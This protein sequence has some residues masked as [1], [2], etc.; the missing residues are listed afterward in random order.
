MIE[1]LM[2]LIPEI[3]EKI[4]DL[5]NYNEDVTKKNP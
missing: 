1:D 5:G 2:Q 4:I 3:E